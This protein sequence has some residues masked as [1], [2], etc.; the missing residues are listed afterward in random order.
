[1]SWN[2][3]LRILPGNL[4][5]IALLHFLGGCQTASNPYPTTAFLQSSLDQEELRHRG[6]ASPS[7]T[8]Q[9]P[10]KPV[11]QRARAAL[12]QA[13]NGARIQRGPSTRY[14]GEP[15]H[16]IRSPS[17]VLLVYHY[18]RRIPPHT[19]L[20]H[21][22]A[23]PDLDSLVIEADLSGFFAALAAEP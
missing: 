9:P 13:L 22:T 18:P 19:L 7:E 11:P 15:D 8:T 14:H 5:L 3:L 1:M 12:R 17:F 16:L 21:T 6:P 23:R 2:R 4:V 10:L 20:L